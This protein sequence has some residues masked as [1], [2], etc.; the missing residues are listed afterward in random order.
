MTSALEAAGSGYTVYLVEK[1]KEIGGRA[2]NYCCKATDECARC[3]ACLVPQVKA[4]VERSPFINILTN[5][6][7]VG[8][9]GKSGDYLVKLNAAGQKKD[10]LVGSVILATGFKPFDA[11]K[12]GEFGYGRERRVITNLELEQMLNEKGSISKVFKNVGRIGFVQ[13][14]GSRDLAMGNNYCSRVCCMVASKLAQ[15]IRY[16]LPNAKISIFYMDIQT[17]GKGFCE[18]MASAGEND[19]IQFIRAIPSKIYEYPNQLL[20]VRYVDF[21]SGKVIEN[22]YDLIV[23]SAAMT[24]QE[25]TSWLAQ[26]FEI[27]LDEHGFFKSL[28]PDPVATRQPGVF[29][30]G[31]CQSPKDIPD[32]IQQAK[33]AA[34]AAVKFLEAGRL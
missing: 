16:Q 11:S 8:L 26:L 32:T 20:T 9:S 17:F 30:A 6:G 33:G 21:V 14:V 2:Y 18:F 28:F 31:A 24:A 1:E 3:S 34:E 25:D 23:L 12:L 27:D 13:C 15:L 19:R 5:S 4:E 22:G 7:L 29:L 10:L